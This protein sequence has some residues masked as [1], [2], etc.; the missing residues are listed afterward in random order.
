MTHALA[1]CETRREHTHTHTFAVCLWR[2]ALW[3]INSNYMRHNRYYSFARLTRICYLMCAA[4]AA[5]VSRSLHADWFWPC[6][7]PCI[8]VMRHTDDALFTCTHTHTRTQAPIKCY[9]RDIGDLSMCSSLVWSHAHTRTYTHTVCAVCDE[10]YSVQHQLAPVRYGWLIARVHMA[11]VCV[12]VVN[13]VIFPR[14]GPCEYG[15]HCLP[16]EW[17]IIIYLFLR[18]IDEKKH[19]WIKG[20]IMNH[21]ETYNDSCCRGLTMRYLRVI[22][23]SL[24]IQLYTFI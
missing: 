7:S 23:F 22:V 5:C 2:Q 24:C 19:E 6:C 16:L 12:C 3:Q 17:R 4:K 1:T 8:R 14:L 21:N 9:L 20:I 11:C 15:R 18:H 10:W 13:D